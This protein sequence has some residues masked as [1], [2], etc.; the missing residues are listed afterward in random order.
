MR[1]RHQLDPTTHTVEL[2]QLRAI[3]TALATRAAG[4]DHPITAAQLELTG[5]ETRPAARPAAT[6]GP[7]HPPAEPLPATAELV[8]LGFDGPPEYPYVHGRFQADGGE[9]LA[10]LHT[11]ALQELARLLRLQQRWGV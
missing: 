1:H 11:A 7:A 8:Q 5:T 4:A 3:N 6:T 2:D 10:D 9:V